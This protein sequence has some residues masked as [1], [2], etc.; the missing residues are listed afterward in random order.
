MRRRPTPLLASLL[1]GLATLHGT[2]AAQVTAGQVDNFENGTTQNWVTN[3]LGMGGTLPP[4]LVPTNIATGGPAGVDDNY[5]RL[6]ASGQ[7][8]PGG[9][10]A[11]LNYA[12]QWVGNYLAAGIG[13]IRLDARNFGTTDLE[14][15]ILFE[16]PALPP[17]PAPPSIEAVSAVPILLRAG[18][19]WQTLTFPLFGAAGL[20]GITGEGGSAG[21]VMTLLAATTGIRLIHLPAGSSPADNGP[22]IAASLGID[23]VTA[24]STV[25]EPTSLALLGTGAAGLL[26]R[27]RRRR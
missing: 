3:L 16:N 10:I 26:A 14:L 19:G 17:N 12:G 6:G 25:P 1:A 22:P 8:G 21:D 4:A 27:R 20:V 18:S 13:A 15:R 2:A 23:N 9:R 7:P 11:V 24:V 5:L